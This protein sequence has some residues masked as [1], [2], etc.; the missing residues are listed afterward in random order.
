MR[1]KTSWTVVQSTR[2]W[3]G[4]RHHFRLI[5]SPEKGYDIADMRGV[6]A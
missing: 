6:C 5:L 1:S 4:D 3:E 2:E